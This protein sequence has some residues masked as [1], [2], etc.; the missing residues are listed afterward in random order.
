VQRSAVTD[1]PLRFTADLLVAAVAGA[2][3]ERHMRI[4]VLVVAL[5]VLSL[6]VVL[7]FADYRWRSQ[8]TAFVERLERGVAT[9][10]RSVYSPAELEG[11]PAPVTRYFRAVL[12][13]GQPFVRRVRFNQTGEFLVRPTPDG[14]RPFTATEHCTALPAGF[15]WDARIRMAPG[16]AVRVRDASIGGAGSM[17][18]SALGLFTMFSVEG[19]PEIGAGALHRYLGEAVWFPT[20]LLPSQGVVWTPIDDSS[21]RAILTVASTTVRLEFR[22]GADGLVRG[23]FTPERARDVNG[24]GVPTPWQGRWFEYEEHDGM[25]IPVRGEVEWILPEG[26]R[27]Y[28]RGR[29][30][31]IS[32]E[33]H[34]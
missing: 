26:P 16:L 13:D 20:A 28:W 9:A 11:L 2:N 6:V 23:V 17:R 22:F 7:A 15:V 29:V 32:Y 30:T 3:S 25:R 5:V 31:E 14:W 8:S 27:V 33:Y 24:R 1:L 19:T 34:E 4:F 12:R 10:P 21:A 18:A